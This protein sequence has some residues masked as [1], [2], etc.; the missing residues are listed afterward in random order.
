LT[1]NK[2][3]KE[4]KKKRNRIQKMNMMNSVK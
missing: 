3:E 2:K 1:A 4:L